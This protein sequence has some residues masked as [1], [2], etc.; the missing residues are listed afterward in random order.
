MVDTG[1][2]KF[3]NLNLIDGRSLSII[4]NKTKW[5]EIVWAMQQK[6]VDKNNPNIIYGPW[7]QPGDYT[8]KNKKYL[9]YRINIYP[10]KKEVKAELCKK[11]IDCIVT[12][13]N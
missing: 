5:N 4:N 6:I 9:G 12:I 13:H 11:E 2:I 7:L 8:P 10:L 3:E 1:D